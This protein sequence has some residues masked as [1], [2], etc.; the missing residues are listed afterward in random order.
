MMKAIVATLFLLLAVGFVIPVAGH[1]EHAPPAAIQIEHAPTPEQCKA[2]AD[3][4]GIPTASVLFRSEA[5][6]DRLS[7]ATALNRNVSAKTLDARMKQLGQCTQTD[8]AQDTRYSE[9][10]RAYAIASLLRFAN[11]MK[12]HN[13]TEQFFAEDEQGQR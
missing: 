1:I 13:L 3:A 4:W 8:K 12:R 10:N 11:Y 2:D 5:E 9:A 6:F 7:A